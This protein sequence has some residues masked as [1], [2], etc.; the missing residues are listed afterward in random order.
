MLKINTTHM[1]PLSVWSL[2]LLSLTT[3]ITPSRAAEPSLA[4]QRFGFY[5][6]GA[7]GTK[8]IDFVQTIAVTTPDYCSDIKGDV[9]V[10]FKAPGMFG[11]RALCWQ[12]PTADK[13]SP[14]GHDAEV[15]PDIK[16]DAAGNGSFVFHAD[17]FPNGPVTIRIQAKDNTNKQDICEL[18]LYNKDGV[19]WNQGIPKT[20]PP[21]AKG[22]KLVFSDDFNGPLS[23]SADGKG[24]RYMEHKTGGGDYSG[25]PFSDNTPGNHLFSQAGT[26]LRIHASKPDGT[27]GFAGLLSSAHAD[28]SGFY[29]V[30]PC[31]FECRFLVQ[32]ATGTWPAFWFCTA[33]KGMKGW[34]SLPTLAC[35][36]NDAIEAYGGYG[37]KNPN[38]GGKYSVGTHFW[39][40]DEPDWWKGQP[41]G[42]VPDAL[43]L[44]GKSTWSTTFH[45]YGMLITATD[46]VF[47]FDDIEVFRHRS[48][49]ISK[50]YPSFFMINNAIGGSSGWHIDLQR[51]GNQTDMWVDF[52]RVYSSKPAVTGAGRL[53]GADR[54]LSPGFSKTSS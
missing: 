2:A 22:M 52:V 30:P 11:A 54:Q 35:D 38:S 31:Y 46:T 19:V 29:A 9:T 5:N 13:P 37:P 14:W 50:T 3:I 48:G 10:T 4:E 51:Y 25:W 21:A 16:L 49:D 34:E 23:V 20:D 8:G 43:E 33:N 17:Q 53:H 45:T 26:F 1:H 15:A 44:G 24:A 39:H 12:Q 40:Q 28:G 27:N 7:D 42:A 36:E 6:G 41:H 32:N 18:Q 47:Y